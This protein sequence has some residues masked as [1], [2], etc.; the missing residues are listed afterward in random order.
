MAES[1][2][3]QRLCQHKPIPVSVSVKGVQP[4]KS[5]QTSETPEMFKLVLNF[6]SYLKKN[7]YYY[8]G[9][10]TEN[11]RSNKTLQR[12]R[13]ALFR[14]SKTPTQQSTDQRKDGAQ[15]QATTWRQRDNT[16]LKEGPLLHDSTRMKRPE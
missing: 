16:T 6:L 13:S 11:T 15:T 2:R 4:G 5:P 10:E 14:K 1:A 8:C 7:Y 9:K 12:F 3:R